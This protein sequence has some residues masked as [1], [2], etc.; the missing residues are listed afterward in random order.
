VTAT[1][2]HDDLDPGRTKTR[3]P[4]PKGPAAAPLQLAQTP[5]AG[6]GAPALPAA[7]IL[8][9]AASTNKAGSTTLPLIQP[10][11]TYSVHRGAAPAWLGTLRAA[12][13]GVALHIGRLVTQMLAALF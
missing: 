6:Q 2:T 1:P 8:P 9:L 7:T 12:L 4:G 10:P 5:V 3:T 13:D 11:V